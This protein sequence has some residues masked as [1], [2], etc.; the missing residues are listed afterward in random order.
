MANFF[1]KNLIAIF[2]IQNED[3]SAQWEEI[4][5]L[6]KERIEK[7]AERIKTLEKEII[8]RKL[9][10][11]LF[12]SDKDLSDKAIEL[13]KSDKEFIVAAVKQYGSALKYASDALKS[14]REIVLTA[15]KQDGNAL[16]FASDTLKSDTE[17]VLT[18]Y[19]QNV[20]ALHYASDTLKN[21]FVKVLS[22]KQ[23]RSALEFASDALVWSIKYKWILIFLCLI[24]LI[25]FMEGTNPFLKP[26]DFITTTIPI[27]CLCLFFSYNIYHILYGKYSF[28]DNVW[29]KFLKIISL[30][31]QF[32]FI[33]LLVE[34]A[35]KFDVFNLYAE[36]KVFQEWVI[37]Y[38]SQN[39]IWLSGGIAIS[40]LLFI[41][42]Q[43]LSI[44][45][46]KLDVLSET[47]DL[48]SEL[49]KT[50]IRNQVL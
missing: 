1:L 25:P 3:I 45:K 12:L 46:L 33:P 47:K 17:I 15:V 30:I 35:H 31:G 20:N 43:F 29:L 26:W 8:I 40:F 9:P 37:W 2:S 19:N 13:F 22:I 18:A 16:Q 4:S 27:A 38:F 10:Y 6:Y 50:N 44:E 48:I 41:I 5:A 32:V 23:N 11:A 49:N 36:N 34:S 14:D 24:F 42:G 28:S 7:N 21:I 39:R